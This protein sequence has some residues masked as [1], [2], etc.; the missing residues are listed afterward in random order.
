MI[1]K[2]RLLMLSSW[3]A[4]ILAVLP[5][6]ATAQGST[7]LSGFDV[8]NTSGTAPSFEAV[9]ENLPLGAYLGFDTSSYSSAQASATKNGSKVLWTGGTTEKGEW[10]HFGLFLD[11]DGPLAP[12]AVSYTYGSDDP[13]PPP[14]P[15]YQYWIYNSQG[16][17]VDVITLPSGYTGEV[18]VQRRVLVVEGE[19]SFRDLT[20]DGFLWNQGILI[21]DDFVAVPPEGLTYEYEPV[22]DNV[23]AVMMFD[24]MNMNTGIVELT[25]VNAFRAGD[26]CPSDGCNGNER[27]KAKARDRDGCQVKGIVTGGTPGSVYGISMPGACILRPA[28]SNG[29]AVAKFKDLPSGGNIVEVPTCGLST[30]VTCP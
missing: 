25:F 6:Q 13:P 3:L 30:A 22:P 17:P 19:L 18:R 7:S 2:S 28:N 20:R 1:V 21:D 11:E 10:S 14:P 15:V 9:Y 27:L 8:L 4:A 23:W 29:K 26:N 12:V 16:L 5:P 24:V